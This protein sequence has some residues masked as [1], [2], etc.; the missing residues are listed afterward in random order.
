MRQ[1]QHL[2]L[3]PD[4]SYGK[5][6]LEKYATFGNVILYV[7]NINMAVMQ[8]YQV[9]AVVV[10]MTIMMMMIRTTAQ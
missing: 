5:C 10:I 7:I 1:G 6:T 2:L 4:L 3:A 8:T 9:V